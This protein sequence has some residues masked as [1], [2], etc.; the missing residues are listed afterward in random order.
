MLTLESKWA[1]NFPLAVSPTS[2]ALYSSGLGPAQDRARCSKLA[3]LVGV[4]GDMMVQCRASIIMG[5]AIDQWY[6]NMFCDRAWVDMC[7]KYAWYY[8]HRKL[9]QGLPEF[10]ETVRGAWEQERER[11]QEWEREQEQERE[12]TRGEDSEGWEETT[13]RRLTDEEGKW[14][15][16]VRKNPSLLTDEEKT[17]V[18]RVRHERVVAEQKAHERVVAEKKEERFTRGNRKQ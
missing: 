6:T 1:L 4:W 13:Q 11:E 12:R 9:A 7:S 15:Q 17:V 5:S 8:M 10:A 2:L 3:V 14:L 18:E 16:E